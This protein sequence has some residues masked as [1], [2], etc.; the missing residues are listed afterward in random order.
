MGAG[1]LYFA[2]QWMM[3]EMVRTISGLPM[4]EAGKLIEGIQAPLDPEHV[5]H[6][7]F[8]CSFSRGADLLASRQSQGLAGRIDNDW[9]LPTETA[10]GVLFGWSPREPARQFARYH[11]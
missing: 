9:G 10:P 11:R 5:S 7:V 4:G 2:S 6:L 1:H 3:A 8:W